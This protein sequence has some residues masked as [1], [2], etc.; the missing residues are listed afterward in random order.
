[1]GNYEEK[2]KN[3]ENIL[4]WTKQGGGAK[5]LIPS[6]P[7][8]VRGHPRNKWADGGRWGV[9]RI[10]REKSIK[11]QKLGMGGRN[12]A[13]VSFCQLPWAPVDIR[14]MCGRKMGDGS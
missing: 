14:G 6:A 3:R 5:I 9:M 13:S 7:A 4:K 11:W 12:I 1:M 2:R 8:D 10:N